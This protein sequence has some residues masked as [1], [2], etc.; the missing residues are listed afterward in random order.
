MRK[1][2]Q[3]GTGYTF[4][5]FFNV[6]KLSEY[7]LI[8][9]SYS[10]KSIEILE[11]IRYGCSSTTSQACLKLVKSELGWKVGVFYSPNSINL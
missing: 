3:L 2:A 9:S 5:F 7:F 8:A 6:P 11:T 1:Y 4:E 10:P